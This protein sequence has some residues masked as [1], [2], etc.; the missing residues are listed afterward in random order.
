[1][2]LLD[3]RCSLPL[4]VVIEGG[5]DVNKQTQG[6]HEFINGDGAGKT[7]LPTPSRLT[8]WLFHS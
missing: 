1:L 4:S 6:F 2:K 5:N 3:S 7:V 8:G